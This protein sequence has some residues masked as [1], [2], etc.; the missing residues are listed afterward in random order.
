MK[1]IEAYLCEYGCKKYLRTKSGMRQHEKNCLWNPQQKACASCKSNKE[2]ELDGEDYEDYCQST[3]AAEIKHTTYK[4]RW[5]IKL[6]F[7]IFG[8]TYAGRKDCPDWAELA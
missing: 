8:A 4:T 3:G 5:C 6:E 2:V 7:D 1:I